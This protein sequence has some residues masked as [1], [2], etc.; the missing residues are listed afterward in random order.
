MSNASETSSGYSRSQGYAATA[1]AVPF[2]A[3]LILMLALS[4]LGEPVAWKY[5]VRTVICAGL[6]VWFRPWQWYARLQLRNLPLAILTGI[7]VFVLWAAPEIRWGGEMPL[8]QRLYLQFGVF[9]L[10]RVPVLYDN[11]SI[12]A[13]AAC[14]WPLTIVRLLGSAFIIAVIEEFFWRGFFYR[15]LIDRQ[16][17]TVRL[18]RFDV[19]AF[20]VAG[21]L[22]GL[23]HN[24]WV[25][26]ILAGFAYTLL[27]IRTRDIWAV[28]IAHILTNLLLGLYVL[29]ADAY[30]FW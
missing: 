17:L 13:P 4:H 5:A 9:P 2:L 14:G 21:L 1:H 29:R 18:S 8:L 7:A 24:R 10:G 19:E 16:F 11:T 3:W 22:F 12:Y 6:F 25:A 28:S 23:E 15:W 27:M 26:G 30:G 20:L